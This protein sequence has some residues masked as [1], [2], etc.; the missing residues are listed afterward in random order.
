MSTVA[1]FRA[2]D[3][4]AYHVRDDCAMGQRIP[5]LRRLEGLGSSSRRVCYQCLILLIQELGGDRE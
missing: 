4:E 2:E 3:S 1:P 5:V